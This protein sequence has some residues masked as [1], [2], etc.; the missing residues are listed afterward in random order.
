MRLLTEL[1]TSANVIVVALKI[2]WKLNVFQFGRELLR[3]GADYMA[4]FNAPVVRVLGI[5]MCY[6][7]CQCYPFELQ[8]KVSSPS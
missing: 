4:S 6:A 5:Y 3:A 8:I 2:T 1:L 7:V